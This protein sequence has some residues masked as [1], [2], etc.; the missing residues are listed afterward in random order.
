[1][2]SVLGRGLGA[3]IPT[4]EP[5]RNGHVIDL[6]VREIFPNPNQPRKHFDEEKL[7]E[8]VSS[9]QEHGVIQPIVVTKLDKGYQ[10]VVGERRWRAAKSAGFETIPAVIKELTPQARVAVALVE[11]L[12]RHDLNALEEAEAFRVLMDG[13]GLTQEGLS[14]QVGRSRP[15]ITNTLR[16]LQL[17]ETI[18]SLVMEAK[19][20]PG[21]ARALLSLPDENTAIRLALHAA[22]QNLS[23]REIEELV[24][25]KLSPTPSTPKR[26]SSPIERRLQKALGTSVKI[27]AR[28]NGGKIEIAYRSSRDLKSFVENL[29][30]LARSSS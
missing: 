27:H 24:K 29:L 6:L 21:H 12:Q 22:E 16:L 7:S 2:R 11:N 13:Y 5:S 30:R 8:L 20:S 14:K 28:R 15:H 4:R 23:V 18:K 3:L 9:I 17:P 25:R 26:T 19:I 10:I 1:M